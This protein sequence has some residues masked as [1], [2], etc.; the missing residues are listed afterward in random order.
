MLF[1]DNDEEEEVPLLVT[2]SGVGLRGSRSSA[3]R[4]SVLCI[5]AGGVHAQISAPIV[6]GSGGPIVDLVLATDIAFGGALRPRMPFAAFCFSAARPRGARCA[7]SC[8]LG[9]R[10][11]RVR[12]AGCC[13]ADCCGAGCCG[14]G[15]CGAGCCGAGCCG[16]GCS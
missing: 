11:A 15:C 3:V 12:A 14:A 7:N 1:D 9:R 5:L 4:A 2:D 8:G 16:A 13:G 6:C 10:G